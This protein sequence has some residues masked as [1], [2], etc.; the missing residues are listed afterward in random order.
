MLGIGPDAVQ[1]SVS[2]DLGKTP[3][4]VQQSCP[5]QAPHHS[6]L[7]DPDK[8]PTVAIDDSNVDERAKNFR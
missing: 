1:L 7:L 8:E 6:H 2:S 5:Q 3:A 4:A